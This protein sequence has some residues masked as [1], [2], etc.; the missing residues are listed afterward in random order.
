MFLHIGVFFGY[1]HAC[2]VFTQTIMSNE[3][4][5]TTDLDEVSASV[6]YRPCGGPVVPLMMASHSAGQCMQFSLS[7]SL[8][9]IFTK[10]C[11]PETSLKNSKT[12]MR[13]SFQSFAD[14]QS[15]I[16]PIVSHTKCVDTLC[17]FVMCINILSIYNVNYVSRLFMHI[18]F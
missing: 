1:W 16:P 8:S 13:S 7:L 10:I 14:F 17:V 12:Y 18:D 9:L 15:A 6:S 4:N 3:G 11:S 2:F 5:L